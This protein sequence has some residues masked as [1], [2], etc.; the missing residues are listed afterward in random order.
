MASNSK[1]T[2][3]YGIFF[4]HLQ[5]LIVKYCHIVFKMMALWRKTNIGY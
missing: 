5:E 4:T 2:V 3:N 1:Q